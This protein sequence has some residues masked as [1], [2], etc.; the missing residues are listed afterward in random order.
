V[1]QEEFDHN[2]WGAV[3]MIERVIMRHPSF[4]NMKHVYNRLQ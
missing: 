4:L 1:C 3:S 2:I